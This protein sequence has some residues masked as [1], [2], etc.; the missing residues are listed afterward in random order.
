MQRFAMIACLA[1]G[2][3]SIAAPASSQ[4][5]ESE[6]EVSA[7]RAR[8]PQDEVIYFLLPDR[9]ENGDTRN[10]RGGLKGDR[11][12][13]GFDPSDKGFFHGGDLKGVERRLDYIQALGATAVWLTPVFANKPVQGPPGAE[14]AGYHGYWAVDFTKIDPHLGTDADFKAL[15]DAVH[16]RGMKFYMDI[17]VNHTADV[18]R[19]REC[20]SAC[21]YRSPADYPYSRRG[22]VSGE[23][24]NP[25]FARATGKPDFAGIVRPDYA[26][27]PYVPRGEG[28][29]K[30]PAWLN[31]PVYY[32]N[33]GDEDGSGQSLTGGDFSGLDDLMTE[34]PRVLRG[35]ID[36]YGAWIDGYG[37]DG[38]RL[39]TERHVEPAFWRG[40]VPA[41]MARAHARGIPNFH[42]F[43]E[44]SM[45]T[46]DPATTARHSREDGVASM[47]D[48]PLA[49]AVRL[50][51]AGDAGTDLLAEL[52][53]NDVL[54]EGGAATAQTLPTFVSNHD[55]GRFGWF[56]Q[57]AF[58]AASPDE[59]MRRVILAHAM[60]LTL[61]GVPVI[62]YGDEQGFAGT[63]GDQAARQDMFPSKVRLYRDELRLGADA[64]AAP[65]FGYDNPIFRA[66]AELASI[67]RNSPTLSRGRQIT[68]ASSNRPG[69]FAPP[70][71]R[72]AD[73]PRDGA[74][75][76]AGLQHIHPT[77]KCICGG[78]AQLD[79]FR[80]ASWK[81]HG[82]CSCTGQ[83][84]DRSGPVGFRHLRCDERQLRP[85]TLRVGFVSELRKR[86]L[87]ESGGRSPT[88]KSRAK[89][90][91]ATGG[92]RTS[93]G[94]A[95]AGVR[96]RHARRYREANA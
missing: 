32:H 86:Q 68:R 19:Y 8:L 14:S 33:R 20:E 16:A 47:L 17:V 45:E 91:H 90:A 94:A 65:A 30:V 22:G 36:I 55:K 75:N 7:L 60:M 21:P 3:L 41:M 27:T 69:L 61:R 29:A 83:L 9:F 24:L 54:Y 82:K 93:R 5:A 11:L 46:V 2:L 64:G 23:A 63:G 10:D 79:Q 76:P 87:A 4:Q 73:R 95:P 35:M 72:V 13:T 40:F 34:H 92:S 31:D 81:M 88:T 57:R 50:T 49:Q 37:I 25:G 12:R 38:F 52:F 6:S 42:I 89:Q 85:Y 15:V 84:S 26:Y 74:R 51:V 59:V 66:I 96:E 62:Y 58:P 48:Y 18:I 53:A 28:R 44:V 78:W 77:D 43:G 39:D 70:P 67:R 80:C 56:V 71:P 1:A